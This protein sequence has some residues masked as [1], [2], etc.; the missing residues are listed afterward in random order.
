[1]YRVLSL[2]WMIVGHV[3]C[4]FFFQAVVYG[5]LLELL[6]KKHASKLTFCNLLAYCLHWVIRRSPYFQGLGTMIEE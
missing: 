2:Y 4:N 3:Q 6:R 1:M 5:S